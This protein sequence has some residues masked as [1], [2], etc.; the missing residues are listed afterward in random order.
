MV[1]LSQNYVLQDSA[2]ETRAAGPLLYMTIIIAQNGC[3]CVTY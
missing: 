1:A 2:V 3:F